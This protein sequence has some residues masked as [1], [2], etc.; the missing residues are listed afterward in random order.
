MSGLECDGGIDGSSL[1]EKRSRARVEETSLAESYIGSSGSPAKLGL[2]YLGGL[3][4]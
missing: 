3:C 4:R 2:V 1:K